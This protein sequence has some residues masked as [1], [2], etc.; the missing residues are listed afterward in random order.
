MFSVL[1]FIKTIIP[2]LFGTGYFYCFS[3]NGIGL[4]L[5]KSVWYGA[6]GGLTGLSLS[7]CFEKSR[8]AIITIFFIIMGIIFDTNF[9]KQDAYDTSPLDKTVFYTGYFISRFNPYV[10]CDEII[11]DS[12][13]A[14]IPPS[15]TIKAVSGQ[16]HLGVIYITSGK[17]LLRTISFDGVS[18]S[19]TL[20]PRID[21]GKRQ[22]LY[23]FRPPS[24][25]LGYDWQE[26]NGIYRCQYYERK[27]NFPNLK[28]AM[29]FIYSQTCEPVLSA[30]YNNQGLLVAWTDKSNRHELTI[31]VYQIL[32]NGQK[33]NSLPNAH[34][35]KLVETKTA[36]Q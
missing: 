13:I 33:P 24:I 6:I 25:S 16:K 27:M 11:P 18:R 28:P 3:Q 17:G 14:V 19:I 34:D 2:R 12:N 32:I 10:A 8:L 29:D 9:N 5:I 36:R 22:Y 20:K 1:Y 26:H 4:I 21:E 31:E 35:D 23:F 30:V 7:L 15:T